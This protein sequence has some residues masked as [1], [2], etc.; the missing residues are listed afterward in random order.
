VQ[1]ANRGGGLANGCQHRKRAEEGGTLGNIGN[2]YEAQG[3]YTQ[4]VQAYQQAMDVLEDVRADAGS[5]Q[6][7]TRFIEDFAT[8]YEHAVNLYHQQDQDDLA[9]VTSERNR[10]RAFLDSLA[11]GSLHLID[12]D[13]NDLLTR[14]Q[15]AYM[16]RQS[17]QD[18]LAL[19]RARIPP[20]STLIANLEKQLTAAEEQ[21]S[22]TLAEIEQRGGQL[23][24]MVLSRTKSV[25]N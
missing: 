19:A 3:R 11:T 6:G 24:A 17:A 13:A 15:T 21:Y 9:F 12:Q 23:A 14:E 16:A 2:L 18:A 5:E 4:A 10:A 25:L 22:K 1:S 20:D 7:R 8:L